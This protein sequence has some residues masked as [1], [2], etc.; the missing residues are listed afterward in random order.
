MR[1]KHSRSAS[2]LCSRDLCTVLLAATAALFFCCPSARAAEHKP[3][4]GVVDFDEVLGQLQSWKDIQAR[5]GALEANAE[6]TF[7]A[8]RKEI[9]R[10]RAELQYF[11]PESKDY[12]KRQAE[13]AARQRELNAQVQRFEA[14]IAE[15]SRAAFSA[16]RRKIQRAVK[17]Y[18]AANA[19]DLVVDSE[20]VLYVADAHEISL[21]VALEMNKRYK[22]QEA[23]DKRPP[24][25]D[26]K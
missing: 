6:K 9:E 17:E 4:V 18:A 14:L 19:F 12:E 11:K 22:K 26:K 16:T 7:A 5:L 13:L 10:I 21:K 24:Q 2:A 1:P 25:K 23:A 15:H 8:Q 20:A 3:K